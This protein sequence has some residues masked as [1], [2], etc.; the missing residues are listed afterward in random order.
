[1]KFKLKKLNKVHCEERYCVK[2]LNGFAALEDFDAQVEINSLGKQ[3]ERIQKFQPKRVWV[4]F[5]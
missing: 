4:I 3:L 2:V 5:N 1:M